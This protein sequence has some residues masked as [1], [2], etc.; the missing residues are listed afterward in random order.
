MEFVK[1]NANPKHRKTTDCV[2]RALSIALNN[3]WE[4]TYRSLVD[5]SIKNYLMCTEKRAYTG[6]LKAKGYEMQKMPKRMDNSR[7]TVKE[8]IDELARPNAVYVINIA[9]HLT[10]VK[11]KVL[12]DSWDCS[13][14]TMGNF[15]IIKA[16]A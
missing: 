14:K 9:H 6:Y 2:I 8:F 4:A 12:L 10:V 11:D 1:Y 3:S 7:Y 15:W 13:K 5:Y 16:G